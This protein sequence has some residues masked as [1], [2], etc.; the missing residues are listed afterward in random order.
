M[1][2][3]GLNK[4]IMFRQRPWCVWSFVFTLW[5]FEIITIG[6]YFTSCLYCDVYVK[7]K[8]VDTNYTLFH[9]YACTGSLVI[10]KLCFS[11]TNK[12]FALVNS[13]TVQG[14]AISLEQRSYEI[15]LAHFEKL[16]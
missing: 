12:D 1:H 4:L 16:I 7:L 2:M 13:S 10:L 8:N 9:S 6:F 11:E 14:H 15:V 3:K 5:P